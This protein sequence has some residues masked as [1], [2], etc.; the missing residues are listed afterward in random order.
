MENAISSTTTTTVAPANTFVATFDDGYNST[1]AV[2]AGNVEFFEYYDVLN[3]NNSP[4][5]K[6][7]SVGYSTVEFAY[8]PPNGGSI[9]IG[10]YDTAIQ[11]VC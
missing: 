10:T 8:I 7:T 11:S 1:V 6:V 4:S 3:N 9:T 2:P 5:I